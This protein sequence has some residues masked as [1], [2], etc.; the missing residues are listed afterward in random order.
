[1]E[2]WIAWFICC[3]LVMLSGCSAGMTLGIMK[4]EPGELQ[5]LSISGNKPVCDYA[6]DVLPIRKRGNQLL[7]SLLI[8]NV[9]LNCLLAIEIAE[10][11]SGLVGFFISTV[12]IMLFAEIIPM[13]ICARHGLMIAAH[14]TWL[15]K[16]ALMLVYIPAFPFAYM[17]DKALG[18]EEPDVYELEDVKRLLQLQKQ[19]GRITPFE[20]SIM[21]SCLDFTRTATRDVMMPVKSTFMLDAE[22]KLNNSQLSTIASN[23]YHRIPVYK[24]DK[25][26]VIGVLS[27]KQFVGVNGNDQPRVDSLLTDMKPLPEVPSTLPLDRCMSVLLSDPRGL[28]VVRDESAV[29][30]VVTASMVAK[31]LG[32]YQ[33]CEDLRTAPA[34]VSYVALSFDEGDGVPGKGLRN[35]TESGPDESSS[36]LGGSETRYS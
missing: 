17:L 21:I 29:I 19:Y 2:D 23:G 3:I 36:L 4:L 13:G 1:M 5:L 33:A 11:T 32:Y 24:K 8:C 34:P 10:L 16:P 14:L 30:G 20:K 35:P 15:L 31:S 9:A 18:E 7:C 6:T 26:N 12:L 25:T 27:L 22:S 28:A